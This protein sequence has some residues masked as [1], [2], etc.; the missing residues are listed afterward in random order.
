MKIEINIDNEII[1]F[2]K[3][4]NIDLPTFIYDCLEKGYT[5]NKWGDITT[6]NSIPSKQEKKKSNRKKKN[7]ADGDLIEN[8]QKKSEPVKQIPI[9]DLYGED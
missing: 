6:N 4:N 2:C 8:K 7:T 9:N 5:Q 3:I 1:D